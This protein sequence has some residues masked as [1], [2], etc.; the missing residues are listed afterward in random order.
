MPEKNEMYLD[1]ISK[2]LDAKRAAYS[3][4]EHFMR[5]VE[6]IAVNARAYHDP[7][8][9]GIQRSDQFIQAANSMVAFFQHQISNSWMPIQEAEQAIQRAAEGLAEVSPLSLF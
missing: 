9:G 3:S 2:R 5:D 4:S 1:K 8:R 7:V 6:Q